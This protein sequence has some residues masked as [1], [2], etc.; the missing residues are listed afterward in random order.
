M[1]TLGS[2]E[3]LEIIGDGGMGTVYKGRD[4]RFDRPVAVKVLHPHFL[5]DAEL[6]AR[7]KTEAVVQAKLNHPNI[8]TV[9][10]FIADDSALAIV[11]ELV[12]GHSL[13]KLIEGVRVPMPAER[14]L[15][16]MS[17]ILSAMA[18]AHEQGLVHRDIK[19]SNIVVKNLRGQEIAKVMDFGIAKILGSEKMRTAT[20][21]KMG[22]LAYMSP[23]HIRSPK[24]VD[25]RSDVYSLGVTLYEMLSGEVPY[26]AESEYDLIRRIVEESPANLS[27]RVAGL[28]PRIA[29][30]VARAVEKDPRERFPTC[31]AFARALDDSRAFPPVAKPPTSP[32][33]SFV[34]PTPSAAIPHEAAAPTALPLR[35]S[36]S[37]LQ[38]ELGPMEIGAVLAIVGLIAGGGY[39]IATSHDEKARLERAAS[40][41]KQR[42]DWEAGRRQEAE[43]RAQQER[44]AREAQ[45]RQ[46]DEERRARANV[47]DLFGIKKGDTAS[48]VTE[49]HGAPESVVENDGRNGTKKNPVRAFVYD[50]SSISF[51]ID[52]ATNL[53]VQIDVVAGVGSRFRDGLGVLLGESRQTVRKRLGKPTGKHNWDDFSIGGAAVTFFYNNENRATRV[54]VLF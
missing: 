11:M 19:P 12:E 30:V 17:Q 23:E 13:D 53:V 32:K 54:W 14:A 9:Y 6:V 28:D 51:L 22:T 43:S 49:K 50:A 7:F 27:A 4:R 29:S 46:A 5:R 42:A 8:V 34:L 44:E 10:D 36:T 38:R 15:A 33:A 48:A 20:G 41:E 52:K 45:V 39:W 1:K 3:V 18:Y 40:V 25:A 31:D 2:Y 21:A 16:L 24:S 47:H 26:R 35:P 37:M